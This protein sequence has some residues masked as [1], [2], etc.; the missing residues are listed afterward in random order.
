MV[1][2]PETLLVPMRIILK[3]VQTHT[4]G[5]DQVVLNLAI[6]CTH[7]DQTLLRQQFDCM[8]AIMHARK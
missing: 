5:L 8:P 6:W 7:I 3:C 4:F 1:A 2:L